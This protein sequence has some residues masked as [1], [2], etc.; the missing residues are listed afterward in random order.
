MFGGLSL[1]AVALVRHNHCL[2]NLAANL[3]NNGMGRAR[4]CYILAVLCVYLALPLV[5]GNEPI[6]CT[7][8]SL[9][10]MPANGPNTANART[11]LGLNWPRFAHSPANLV[12]NFICLRDFRVPVDNFRSSEADALFDTVG[13]IRLWVTHCQTNPILPAISP[14]AFSC[15]LRFFPTTLTP[16]TLLLCYRSSPWKFLSRCIGKALRASLQIQ[17]EEE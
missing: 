13:I 7:V 6:L 15:Y 1:C 9:A 4:S 14:E 5:H 3:A 12:T 17:R 16:T 11:N 10:H 2:A 8:Q